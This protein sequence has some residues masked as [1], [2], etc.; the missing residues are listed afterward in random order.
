MTGWRWNLLRGAFLA[1]VIGGAWW[2]WRDSGDEA[3]RAFQE[4]E[5]TRLVGAALLVVLGLLV[6]GFVWFSAWASYGHQVAAVDVVPLFFVSQLGKYIPGSVWSFAAQAAMGRRH[7]LPPRASASSSVLFLGVHV[8]SGLLLVGVL[9]WGSAVP[10]WLV[11]TA[12]MGGLVGLAPPT[13]RLLGARLA[14]QQC[15]WTLSR[16]LVGVALMVPVWVCYSL[17]LV[18]LVPG[19]ELEQ[20]LALGCAFA[21]AH[22][23]GVAIPLA[24]AGLGAREVVLIALTTSVIGTGAATMVALV[25]RLLHALADFAVAAGAWVLTKSLLT[26]GPHRRGRAIGWDPV[27]DRSPEES[28]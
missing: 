13:Y 5:A 4:I 14:G 21:L 3:L 16:S 19:V 22:G 7:G 10:L 28:P 11:V 26:Q 1:A 25:I 2:S 8:A 17:A 23:A 9:G 15:D 18:L 6:T 20:V 12:L 27:P 24:P